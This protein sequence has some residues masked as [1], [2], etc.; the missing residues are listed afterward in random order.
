MILG[1][2]Y[3][4]EARRHRAACPFCDYAVVRAK[5]EAALHVLAQHVIYEHEHEGDGERGQ[6]LVEWSLIAALV[7]VVSI[8]AL[9]AVQ[10][11]VDGN[12]RN[13]EKS[14]ACPSGLLADG[15]CAP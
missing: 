3:D 14:V 10:K 7:A 2:T 9:G 12:Q 4:A 6:T 5:K 1:T 8:L 15:T 11:A 13:I